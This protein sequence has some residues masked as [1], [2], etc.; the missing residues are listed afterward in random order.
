MRTLTP[1][2]ARSTERPI[3]RCPCLEIDTKRQR[4]DGGGEQVPFHPS[5]FL[6]FISPPF[7][8]GVLELKLGLQ[9]I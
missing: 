2:M 4:R 5:P 6:S 7:I 1:E 8:R 9:L 3:D